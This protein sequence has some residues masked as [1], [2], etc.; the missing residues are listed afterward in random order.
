MA[1]PL[2]GS[3]VR[4]GAKPVAIGIDI[5][6][7]NLRAARVAADGTVLARARAASTRDPAEVL[8]R[9]IALIAEVD[10]PA[11]AAIGIGVPG[12]VDFARRAVLGGGF[13]DLSAVAVVE[14]IEAALRPSRRHRQR[15]GHGAHRRGPPRR[16]PRRPPPRPAH[17][18][19]RHRRRPDGRRP[20]RPRPRR[21]RP[22][23][24]HSRRSRRSALPLRPARLRRADELGHR[25]R[26]PDPRRR[27]SARAR[28]LLP[29]STGR[30]AGDRGAQGI[31]AA[32]SG[33]LRRAIGALVASVDCERV[34]LG[35]GLGREAAAAVAML[36]AEDVLVSRH[37][38]PRRARRRRRHHRGGARGAGRARHAPP[39]H[40]QR[41]AGERQERDRP[42]PLGGHR[43][44]GPRPRYHQGTLPCRDRRRRRPHRPALQPRARARQLPRA[45]RAHRRDPRRNDGDR[46]RLVRLPAARPARGAHRA[47]GHHRSR[48][49]SGATRPRQSLPTATAPVPP[50]G[51]RVIRGPNTPPSSRRSPPR[52]GRW[53]S[54]RCT[55]ST[56]KHRWTAQTL[57]PSPQPF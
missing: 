43:L 16:R 57:P 28:R 22:A 45:L 17:H 39:R 50:I 1:A 26:R 18:R 47:G 34:I 53:R 9:L 52:P 46:R 54:G 13:V 7:T 48:R 2:P 32:W 40:G 24:P 25:P 44:A 35:G 20:D 36:P 21:R 38:R 37:H 10:T 41:R 30:R 14:T 49:D 12:R 29:S 11:V 6:G 56:P 27:A 19:H 31:L 55:P 33:P 15:R 23:R 4:P 5:G 51:Y 8:A 42:R 3:A